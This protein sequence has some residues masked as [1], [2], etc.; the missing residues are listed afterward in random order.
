MKIHGTNVKQIRNGVYY[1]LSRSTL[2][3]GRYRYTIPVKSVVIPENNLVYVKTRKGCF[4]WKYIPPKDLWVVRL[5]GD[6][7]TK[8]TAIDPYNHPGNDGATIIVAEQE[9]NR[10]HIFLPS[11]NSSTKS[12]WRFYTYFF[13]DVIRKSDLNQ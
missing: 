1:T 13:N 10:V 7:G 9:G 6:A 8:L 4:E 11:K 5:I 3:V 2:S 12:E